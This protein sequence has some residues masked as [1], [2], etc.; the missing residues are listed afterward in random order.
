MK[1]VKENIIG[2]RLSS[3][4][5]EAMFA[6]LK[7]FKAAHRNCNVP[8]KWTANPRL[9]S[10]VAVQRRAKRNGTL[11]SDRT[12]RLKDL[13]FSWAVLKKAWETSFAQLERYKQ[14]YGHCNV[15]LFWSR[16]LRLGK[17]VSHQRSRKK[18]N[19]ISSDR[20]ER[21]TALGFV[22]D[23]F[24]AAWETNF[25]ALKHYEKTHGD[26]DVP[27]AWPKNPQ[28]GGWVAR[29]RKAK[30]RGTLSPKK[31][32]RLNALGFRWHI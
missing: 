23:T 6:E 4:A 30:K 15:P 11:N 19:A 16:N 32:E 24:L 22:W 31:I 7:K 29:Q 3:L 5:W 28:L 10:W 25:T 20:V 12:K 9:G 21:L 18:M 2:S 1:H 26:C 13:G 27:A 14:K 17:W 8:V